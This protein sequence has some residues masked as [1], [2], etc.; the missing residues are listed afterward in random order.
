[1]LLI[2]GMI[3]AFAAVEYALATQATAV[4]GEQF[5]NSP[6]LGWTFTAYSMT[7]M[8]AAL[9]GGR[10][11]DIIGARRLVVIAI[12]V[13]TVGSVVSTLAPT[14]E[15]LVAG[16]LIQGVSG[17]LLP[18]LL[19][20]IRESLPEKSALRVAGMTAT[21]LLVA[22][23]LAQQSGGFL[24]D[25]FGWRSIFLVGALWGV[26]SLAMAV[27]MLPRTPVLSV[28]R[29]RFDHLGV[30][31]MTVGSFVLLI[32][33]TQ[34][35]KWG[36]GSALFLG[37]MA[38]SVA[39]FTLWWRHV[40]RHPNPVFNPRFLR[41]PAL[42]GAFIAILVS[43][44]AIYS[45]SVLSSYLILPKQTGLGEGMSPSQISTVFSLLVLVALA[46]GWLGTQWSI[47]RKILLIFSVVV[48]VVAAV[49]FVTPLAGFPLALT[50]LTVYL[51]T[52]L[53]A[54]I[55]VAINAVV[56]KHSPPESVGEVSGMLSTVRYLGLAIGP[57][58]FFVFL[59]FDQ[60]TVDGTEHPGSGAFTTILVFGAVTLL[61]SVIPLYLALRKQTGD[62]PPAAGTEDTKDL[63][64][65]NN[66]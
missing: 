14:I 55:I 38:A 25:A 48:P 30:A 47:S 61:V 26:V 43:Y 52:F 39:V 12:A 33:L 4:M 45:H 8:V 50:V 44:I 22:T 65:T 36:Y 40:K 49:W 60:V 7:A 32:G 3:E 35:S 34:S 23:A 37:V 51:S 18:A 62:R 10:I 41:V 53:G 19:K 46:G 64:R 24:V 2:A 59:R 27:V 28:T 29:E 5:H 6:W 13:S 31:L 20:A 42:R 1:M 11:A 16:R 15:V 56:I 66:L 17:A 57:Q 63:A 54:M 21:V 9:I 58:L